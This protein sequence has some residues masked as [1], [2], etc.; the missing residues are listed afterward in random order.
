MPSTINISVEDIST[1]KSEL[2]VVPAGVDRIGVGEDIGTIVEVGT[3]VGVVT[4]ESVAVF[5]GV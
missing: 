2:D 4:A 1:V 3:G 5:N